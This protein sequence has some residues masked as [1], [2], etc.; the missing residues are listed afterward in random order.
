MSIEA[1]NVENV[2]TVSVTVYLNF[3]LD[4]LRPRIHHV[5]HHWRL[6]HLHVRG[7]HRDVVM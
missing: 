1:L 2:P 7:I 4:V 6:F 5:L 3:E